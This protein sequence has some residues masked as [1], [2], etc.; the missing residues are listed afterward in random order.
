MTQAR[1]GP[2]RRAAARLPD[3]SI[4]LECGHTWWPVR[5]DDGH[6]RARHRCA[7]CPESKRAAYWRQRDV[8]RGRTKEHRHAA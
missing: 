3:G 2:L 5:G 1:R 6:A 4:A 7:F 8:L